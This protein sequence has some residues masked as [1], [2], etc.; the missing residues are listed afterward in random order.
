MKAGQDQ[1]SEKIK[2]RYEELLERYHCK[3][4]TAKIKIDHTGEI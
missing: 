1:Q 4:R 2:I 3:S